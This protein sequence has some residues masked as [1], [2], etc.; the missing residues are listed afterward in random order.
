MV[1]NF[2]ITT[3]KTTYLEGYRLEDGDQDVAC[4]D[5]LRGLTQQHKEP[6]R[7]GAPPLPTAI[8][9]TT[10]TTAAATAQAEA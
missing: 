9:L 4:A 1:R 3:N 5:A 6:H 8:Q 2:E 7:R 10:M